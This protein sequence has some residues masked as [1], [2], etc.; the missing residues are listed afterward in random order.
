VGW[1]G[2]EAIMLASHMV[3]DL[4]PAKRAKVCQSVSDRLFNFGYVL[5]KRP[6]QR[7]S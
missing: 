7:R 6:K 1:T 5:I 4:C 3:R 2:E